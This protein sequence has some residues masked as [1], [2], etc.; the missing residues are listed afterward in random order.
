MPETLKRASVACMDAKR[1]ER[2][3]SPPQKSSPRAPEHGTQSVRGERSH[4]E[5]GNELFDENRPHENRPQMRVIPSLSRDLCAT[6]ARRRA[7]HAG[8]WNAERPGRTFPRRAWKRA[9]MDKGGDY[10]ALVGSSPPGSRQGSPVGSRQRDGAAQHLGVM[11][12][13]A[14]TRLPAAQCFPILHDSLPP[15]T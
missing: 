9:L 1:H 13:Y 10:S 6:K 15:K 4:A 12:D 2:N 8:T 7:S 11:A 3:L 14:I 5:H